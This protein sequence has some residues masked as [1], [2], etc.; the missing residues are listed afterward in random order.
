M[1]QP[2]EVSFSSRARRDLHKLPEK[3]AV[4]CAEFVVGPLAANP[5]RLGKPL[6]GQFAGSRSARRGSYRIIYSIDEDACRIVIEHIDHR[7]TV[8]R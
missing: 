5:Q 8:Y 4:A 2:Y 3:I 1:A 6:I 7:A